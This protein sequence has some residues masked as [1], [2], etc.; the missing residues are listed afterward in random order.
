MRNDL[1]TLFDQ[2]FGRGSAMAGF[3][4]ED[5]RF[6]D[7]DVTEDDK[8]VTVRAEVPGFEPDELNVQ[9]N[10]DT[11]T[12]CAEHRQ[13]GEHERSYRSFRRTVQ[14]PTSVD[15]D[16]ATASYRN[17]VLELHFPRAADALT[18]KISVQAHAAEAGQGRQ[19][20][21]A[22]GREPHGNGGAVGKAA[23][24]AGKSK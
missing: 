24:A 1:N 15:A 7:F 4:D 23:P 13:Q 14:L 9:V 16:K 5:L 8:E 6:W 12:I 18:K 20:T 11:L 19:Q 22:T 10:N 21:P 3:G 17:G 2:F